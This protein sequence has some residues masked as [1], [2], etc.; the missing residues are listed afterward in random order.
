MSEQVEKKEALNIRQKLNA[1]QV[2]LKAPKNQYNSFGKYN[3][4]NC[5]DILE[6]LKDHLKKHNCIVVMSDE[7]QL[8]G[9]RFYI[10]ATSKLIDTE[11]DASIV[12]TSYARETLQKKGM[13]DSQVTGAASSYARKY[14]LNGLFC[15]DDTKDADG[16]EPPKST[17]KQT[18]K[19]DDVKDKGWMNEGTPE[20]EKA[21][22]WI[23]GESD[24]G[25]GIQ[26]ISK[27]YKLSKKVRALLEGA[28]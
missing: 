16:M 21:Y 26:T 4:R 24:K 9:D 27:K 2:E 1:I 3:F 20:Y 7:I 18:Q 11:T 6:G 14:S 22:N 10:K 8:I 28:K 19:S 5:E 13:D 15:I 23:K 12:A 17:P 25:A